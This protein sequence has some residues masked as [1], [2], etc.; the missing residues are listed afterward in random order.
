MSQELGLIIDIKLSL[1][2]KSD[3]KGVIE[4]HLGKV[5]EKESKNEKSV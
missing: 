3:K 1:N 5:V 2:E 4:I